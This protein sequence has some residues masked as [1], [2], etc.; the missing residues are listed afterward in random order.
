MDRKKFQNDFRYYQKGNIFMDDKERV[1]RWRLILGNDSSQQFE[2]MEGMEGFYL[3]EEQM[4]M[5][6]ALAAIYNNSSGGSFGGGGGK[7]PSSPMISKWLGDVRSLFDKELV[8]IIQTDAMEKCGLKQL[9]F[10]TF[11]ARYRISFYYFDV[12]RSD[13]EAF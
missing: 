13:S 6:Q 11:R 2:Q 7:N 3:S 9:I 5:D 4:L 1:K 12:K 8:T 10:R